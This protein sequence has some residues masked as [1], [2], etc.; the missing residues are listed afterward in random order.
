MS[1]H[2]RAIL[3]PGKERSLLNF[4]PW[5]FSG[6]IK[7]FSK[8]P[9]EG[10]VIEII[11]HTDRFLG[12]G[13]Y[14]DGSISIR[15]FSFEK[16]EPGP[17][18]WKAKLQSAYD[19]R[20]A[21]GFT[22]DKGSN[23]YRLFHGEGDGLSGLIIDIY[24]QNAVVQI[25]APALYAV[26]T[27]IFNALDEVYAGKLKNIYDKSASALGKQSSMLANDGFFKGDESSTVVL[28]NGNKFI[29]DW[30]EGQKTGFFIDQRDN[31][32]LLG[33]MSKGKSVLNTFCYSGGFSVYAL[34]AGAALVHSVDS[35]A[36]AM[37]MTDRNI[38][39][40]GHADKHASFTSDVFDFMRSME[41]SY[42]IIILDPPAFAKHLGAVKKA[43]IGYRNLNSEAF[44]RI[45]KGGI[46]F[47]FSCS[48]VIDK[49]LFR[50]I[51]FTAAAESKRNVRILAQLSQ[52]SDHPVN[53]YHPESE[54]LK[55]LVLFIE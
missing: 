38:E 28:E 45:K 36:K 46:L 10:E 13:H 52:P 31:R 4:H 7:S 55:G 17:E 30:I 50:K 6:A 43:S 49:T 35:S 33:E 40:T 37:A 5:V 34:N 51:I 54:Y 29:V 39:L 44:K 19:V 53:I 12:M 8:P 15:I 11:S 25:H 26:R 2:I 41:M 14:H 20:K 3:K 42:D 21:L 23:C 27:D 47:T 24:D 9:V 1:D 16:V 32:K 48:Q 18:L 22:D